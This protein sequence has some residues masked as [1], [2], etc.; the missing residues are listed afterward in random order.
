MR[1]FIIAFGGFFEAVRLCT[2]DIGGHRGIPGGPWELE[3]AAGPSFC[4]LHSLEV[5]N[6]GVGGKGE[7]SSRE[8]VCSLP[9]YKLL[10]NTDL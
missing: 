7:K 3:E 2:M 5:V 4:L 8:Y 9:S 6:G 1:M 10:E